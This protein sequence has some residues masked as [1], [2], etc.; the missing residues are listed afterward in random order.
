MKSGSD[1]GLG[2]YSLAN[3]KKTARNAP[4]FRRY[5]VLASGAIVRKT[6]AAAPNHGASA[7]AVR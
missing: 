6:E 5:A 3:E 1:G 4:F 7:G 2:A